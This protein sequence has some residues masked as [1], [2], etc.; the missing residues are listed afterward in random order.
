MEERG[1]DAL[2]EMD[3]G[4]VAGINRGRRVA[5]ELRRAYLQS[6]LAVLEGIVYQA[7]KGRGG[8]HE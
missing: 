5:Y 2:A 3:R 4:T 8:R 1:R 6:A 7:A